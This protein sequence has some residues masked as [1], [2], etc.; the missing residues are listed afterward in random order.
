M[1]YLVATPIGNLEDIT[2]RALRVLGE[3]DLIAC[4]DTRRARKLLAHYR[5][6]KPLVSYHE[7]NER[8][9]ASELIE[10][11]ESGASIALIS[12]AGMPLI[13]DPGFRLVSQAIRRGIK[14]VPVPG[15]SALVA[16]LAASGLPTNE[17]TFVG[18][19]PRRSN[20]RRARLA[21]LSK[22]NSTLVFYEVPHRIRSTLEDAL[23]VFGDRPAALARE[24]TKL[25]E[26]FIR[27]SLSEIAQSMAGRKPLGEFVLIVGPPQE[28]S[29]AAAPERSILEEVEQLMRGGLDQKAALKQ[30]ARSR[31]ITKGQA[32]KMLIS[33]KSAQKAQT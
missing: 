2:L 19:L 6:S 26:E 5:I 15:P 28:C 21:Q 29:I 4:E 17:F 10:K 24:M 11:L 27:G 33:E 7:H 22:L 23:A 16:A 14:V 1:L 32:Y 9:R 3:V 18:F 8:S 13:S 30:A 12:D 25:H 20:A 31:G